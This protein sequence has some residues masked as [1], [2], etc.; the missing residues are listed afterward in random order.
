MV[1][2]FATAHTANRKCNPWRASTFP[3]CGVCSPTVH[4]AWEVCA[5]A[6][7]SGNEWL[8]SLRL[9]V[10]RRTVC[11]YRYLGHAAQ[12]AAVALASL[13]FSAAPASRKQQ[14]G[15]SN[16]RFTAGAINQ[17]RKLVGKAPV[18]TEW[19]ETY[20][21]T[22]FVPTRFRAPVVLF[23]RPKQ[24]FFYVKDPQMGWGARTMSGVEIHEIDLDH[25]IC[26]VSR[27]FA[28]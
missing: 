11:F 26:S 18:R 15:R 14:T 17:L 6:F 9:K 22:D 3:R 13:L 1:R 12:P 28:W 20:W 7:T 24:P 8:W 19:H 4:I 21:P 5:M 16:F 2:S 10:R 27:T 23:K 25:L